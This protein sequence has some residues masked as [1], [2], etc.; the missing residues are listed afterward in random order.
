MSYI[1]GGKGD[2]FEPPAK[3]LTTPGEVAGIP[4]SRYFP[5]F[6]DCDEQAR[7]LAHIDR[8]PWL[9][10]LDRRVQH[11]GWRYDYRA[12]TVTPDFYCGPL[13]GW[14]AGIAEKLCAN[15]RLFDRTPDQAIDNEYEPGQGIAMHVD[16][17]CFGPTVATISLGDEW[18]MDMRPV[19]G[20]ARETTAHIPLAPGSALVFT[21]EARYRWLHGIAKRKR[22][23]DG[24]GW[25][26]R[27]RRVSLTF[28]T[29]PMA[30]RDDP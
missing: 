4:G 30:D 3:A 2:L 26:P 23:R 24:A 14:L 1:V 12:R 18:Q 28:R 20:G 10:D 19:S 16:R 25:R 21:G 7:A 15:T 17:Q 6:L 29:V 11:Y 27:R 5:A 9:T 22:E 8:A 13:P